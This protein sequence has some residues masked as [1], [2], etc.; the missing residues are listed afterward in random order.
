LTLEDPVLYSQQGFPAKKEFG[1]AILVH[2]TTPRP[3]KPTHDDVLVF[4]DEKTDGTAQPDTFHLCP[5]GCQFYAPRK[6]R[7]FD[8]LEF[9]IDIPMGKK[10]MKRQT[11][12]GTVVR[13]QREDKDRYRIWLHFLD[14]PA[15]SRK[16]IQCVSKTG[17][18]LYNYCENF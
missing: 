1:A 4:V 3:K 14:L 15:S 10:G 5:L 6:M 16:H 12:T 17:K 8:V 13:C 2:A 9:A 18:Y 7:E 11:C